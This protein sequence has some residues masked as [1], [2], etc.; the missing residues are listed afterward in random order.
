MERKS[1]VLTMYGTG[2]FINNFTITIFDIIDGW[3]CSTV[4]DYCSNIN[5]LKLKDDNWIY[6]SVVK[7]NEKIRYEKPIK[8]NF[9]ILR[10]LNKNAIQIILREIN[11]N[12][13]AQALKSADR[14][15]LKT[16]LRSISKRAANM[17]LEEMEYMGPIRLE[18]AEKAQKKI[19]DIIYHLE[20]TGEIVIPKFSQNK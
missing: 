8:G 4:R 17:L 18:D 10:F 16:V 19:V 14:D 13:L 12:V 20:M 1:I 7:E 3:G 15:I 5:E 6:A 11:Y 9:E 2:N